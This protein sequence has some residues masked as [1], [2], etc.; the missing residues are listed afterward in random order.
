MSAV[1]VPE[2]GALV[3][4]RGRQWIASRI[5]PGSAP[6]S[7]VV[8]ELQS[9]MDGHYGQ[10]LTVVWQLEPD[11]A[12]LKLSSLPQVVPGGFDR[13]ERLAA[14]LDAVRWSA[15]TS[16]DVKTLQSPFRS[17]VAV[18]TYQLEPVSRALDAPRVNLL[19][20]DDVGLGKTIEAGLVLQELLLRHRARRVMVVC[21]AGLTVKWRDELA[22]KFG[23][24][25]T[26]VNTEA[27]AQLRRRKGSSANPFRV[28]PRTIVSLP[29]LRGDKAQRI[30]RELLPPDGPA[31]PRTF[32]L[33]ILDEAHH[34]APAAPKQRYAVDSEQT[35]LIRWLAPHF[36]H[37]LFLSAT[38]HNGYQESFTA[39]L[40][41]VD[42]QRFA[43]GISPDPKAQKEVVVRRLKS[44]PLLQGRFPARRNIPI[45]VE[46]PQHERD[47][48]DLLAWFAQDRAKRI[49]PRHV[50][51]QQIADL[52]VLLLKKRM[53]SSPAAFLQTVTTYLDTAAT[54][55]GKPLQA[56]QQDAEWTG[57]LSL[58]ATSSLDD[59][60]LDDAETGALERSTNYLPG[61]ATG[62]LD[63]LRRMRDWA[64]EHTA[65]PDAKAL[66]LLD[67]L[68]AVCRP[69]QHWTNERVVVFTEYR[70][71]QRWLMQI[72][73][74]EGFD[75]DHVNA[76][77]GGMSVDEREEVRRRFQRP[78]GPDNPVRILIATD[79]AGEGIDL[80]DYCHR[81]VNYDI[82]FNPNKLEQR[83]GRIDRYGQRYE[84]E[85]S[86]FVGVGWDRANANCYEADLE[87]LSRIATKVARM[88]ADLGEVNAVLAEKVQDKMLGRIAD[89]D[90]EHASVKTGP[91]RGA[92]RTVL[93]AD[94]DVAE[95]I[96][97]IQQKVRETEQSLGISPERIERVVATALELDGQLPL[98]PHL[99]EA[100]LDPHLRTVPVL[101][102]SWADTVA[103]LRDKDSGQ[104]LPITFAK[105]SVRDRRADI[106]LAHLSH[107]LVQLATR[108]LTQTTLNTT[109]VTGLNRVAAIVSDRPELRGRTF[110]GA[111]A[112]F[113]L[114]GGDHMRLHEEILHVGGFRTD[115]GR[116]ARESS[117]GR[118]ADILAYALDRG[119]P[120]EPR[121]ADR[122]AAGWDALAEP[123]MQSLRVR[124]GERR[125]SLERI[126]AAN[127]KREQD[128]ITANLDRFLKAL[129][130]ELVDEE[131]LGQTMIEI[132][133]EKELAQYRRDRESWQARADRLEDDRKHETELIAKRY[134]GV[135]D[136]LFPVAV[137]FVIPQSEAAR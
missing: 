19:L 105:E 87:F 100:K 112:R 49:S 109:S 67:Y 17:G 91:A 22:E 70:D 72:L 73:G 29:W 10:T 99:D 116:F 13:P 35:K 37:R 16:A 88:E 120:A 137:V 8:V 25:F 41:I 107:P 94:T 90:V 65:N 20:A 128:R 51:G 52:V 43:R 84:P 30:L 38:P 132:R 5:A 59:L 121:L 11:A 39:L 53:F 115:A 135:Q 50:G 106:A 18:E 32:D 104:L 54:R 12:V 47:V 23:L 102:G 108:I 125:S 113:V 28:Y 36:E 131:K 89:Y 78:V 127:R 77:H 114:V 40:E 71:T 57:Q 61:V 27:C 136:L 63:L 74:Q 14:F 118:V 21:P 101:T 31:Y 93:P 55:E 62:E 133:D 24:D 111:Y 68:R 56:A 60:Q 92:A 75:A 34:V 130:E 95:Q 86:H 69:D 110:V 81:L 134:E 1:E 15:V 103:G 124:A 98:Q 126:L 45:P 42:D 2:E 97:A 7:P 85:V 79:A 58:L 82:P 33:L 4:V 76:L 48:H 3:R 83:I 64:T 123:L 96:S 26:I 46:Y 9:V 66:K 119:Q 117:V 129:R 44:D 80:Q 6:D 122:L